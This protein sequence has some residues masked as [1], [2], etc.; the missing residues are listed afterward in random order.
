MNVYRFSNYRTPSSPLAKLGL[1]LVGIALLALSFLVGIVFIAIAAGL[2]ILGAIGF[3]IRN[4]LTRGRDSEKS[5]DDVLE[6]E[7]RVVDRDPRR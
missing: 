7:Y 1:A 3:S 2:A 6:V 4:W 5:A